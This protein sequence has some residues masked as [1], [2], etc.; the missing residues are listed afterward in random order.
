M[1]SE[2][3]KCGLPFKGRAFLAEIPFAAVF[4]SVPAGSFGESIP[5]KKKIVLL[6]KDSEPSFPL[7]QC[8]RAH[9]GWVC[10][11]TKDVQR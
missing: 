4:G 3:S 2:R 10:V 1:G 9:V 6:Q 5:V 7:P 8:S 11:S